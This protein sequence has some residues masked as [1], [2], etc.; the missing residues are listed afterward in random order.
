[1]GGWVGGWVGVWWWWVGAWVAGWVGG[2]ECGGGVCVWGGGDQL[3]SL[4]N[5]PSCLALGRSIGHAN[6]YFGGGY[7]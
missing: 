2:W 7:T 5:P 4:C 3:A 1:V 6:I